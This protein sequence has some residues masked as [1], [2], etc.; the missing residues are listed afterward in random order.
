LEFAREHQTSVIP[1]GAGTSLAGQVVGPGI[2]VDISKYMD[3]IL[4][5]NRNENWILVQPGVNLSELNIYL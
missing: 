5:F 2:V 4:E 1:R 3:Q